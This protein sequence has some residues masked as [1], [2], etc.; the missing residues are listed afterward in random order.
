MIPPKTASEFLFRLS[1]SVIC[2]FFL[3]LYFKAGLQKNFVSRADFGIFIVFRTK[4]RPKTVK[5]I[6]AQTKNTDLIFRAFK[7]YLSSD[8]IPLKRSKIKGLSVNLTV[9]NHYTGGARHGLTRHLL[10]LI[11]V[12]MW[13]GGSYRLEVSIWI[14]T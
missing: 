2:H 13:E 11:F 14:W 1:L 5:T 6:I 8:T 4:R 10:T 3:V 12:F 9:V 7:K